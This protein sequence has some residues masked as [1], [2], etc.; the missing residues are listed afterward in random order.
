MKNAFA[1]ALTLS[2][3]L[4]A[5]AAFAGEAC[6]HPAT[7]VEFGDPEPG[8]EV[9]IK[10]KPDSPLAKALAENESVGQ[11]LRK[12]ALPNVGLDFDPDFGKKF[13]T[14]KEFVTG[15]ACPDGISKE[16]MLWLLNATPGVEN[17]RPNYKLK[18]N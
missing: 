4:V 12:F 3:S 15:Y 5:T 18:I 6:K 1:T 10:V 16:K 9:I 7:K 8:L 14:A 11:T 13:P 2:F 17:A